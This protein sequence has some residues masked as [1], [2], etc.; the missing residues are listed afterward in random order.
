MADNQDIR[1]AYVSIL[2]QNARMAEKIEGLL[3]LAENNSKTMQALETNLNQIEIDFAGMKKE[4][5]IILGILMLGLP[6]V[7]SII[8]K[9]FFS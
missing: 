4:R 7:A 8:S 2:E 6:V 3:R 9:K 1:G 5:N